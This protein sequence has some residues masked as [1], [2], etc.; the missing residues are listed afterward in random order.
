MVQNIFQII[1]GEREKFEKTLE[2]GIKELE[3]IT[4]NN[5]SGITGR[6]A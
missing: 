5:Q 3:F 4:K 1:E 2:K 6:S